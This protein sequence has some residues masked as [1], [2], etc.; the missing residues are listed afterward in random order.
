MICESA[1]DPGPEFIAVEAADTQS[2]RF[3]RS[4]GRH[5]NCRS[6]PRLSRVP[7]TAAVLKPLRLPIHGRIEFVPAPFPFGCVPLLK[8]P[9][10]LGVLAKLAASRRHRSESAPLT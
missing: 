9:E 6:V 5:A 1:I 4:I 8:S 3:S 10:L 7:V 2:H